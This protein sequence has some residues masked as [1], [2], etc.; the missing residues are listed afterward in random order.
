MSTL[1]N[2]DVSKDNYAPL[3]MTAPRMI[4]VFRKDWQLATCGLWVVQEV[5]NTRRQSQTVSL[6]MLQP[7]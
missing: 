2:I 4:F 6:T 3:G 5:T 7:F 1:Q